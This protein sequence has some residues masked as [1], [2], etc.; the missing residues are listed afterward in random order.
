MWIVTGEGDVVVSSGETCATATVTNTLVSCSDY[1]ACA[2]DGEAGV[3]RF[4]ELPDNWAESWFTYIDA[5]LGELGNNGNPED[6]WGKWPIYAGQHY[7][8][9]TLLTYVDGDVLYLQYTTDPDDW[10]GTYMEGCG[11]WSF[12]DYHIDVSDDLWVAGVDP[13][14]TKKGNPIPGQC[15]Y[16]DS[17][18]PAEE[19]VWIETDITGYSGT[20]YIFAHSIAWWCEG[21][22]PDPA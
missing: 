10:E 20:I 6:S 13:L 18:D 5:T 22:C 4:D 11:A 19:T 8:V 1:T 14:L 12:T 3:N 2:A 16:S 7:L 21:S 17:F 9:G 15:E